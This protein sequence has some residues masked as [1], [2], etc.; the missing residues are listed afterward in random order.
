[1]IRKSVLFTLFLSQASFAGDGDW[2]N[3]V[4]PVTVKD[5]RVQGN[6]GIISFRTNEPHQNIKPSCDSGYYVVEMDT[7]GQEIYSI[8]LAA[9]M[10]SKQV[11]INIDATKCCLLYTSPSPRD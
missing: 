1:M 11:G 4:E 10:A 7:M 5:I 9:K 8:L 2:Y 6:R 3:W